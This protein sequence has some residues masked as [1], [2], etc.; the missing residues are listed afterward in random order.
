VD[1]APSGVV[2]FLSRVVPILEAIAVGL[3]LYLLGSMLHGP[4]AGAMAAVLWLANPV[5]MGLGHLDGVDLPVA[6][7]AVLVSLALLRWLRRRGRGSVNL[8]GLACGGAVSAGPTGLLLAAVAVAVV[9]V[10]GWRGRGGQ[11]WRALVPGSAVVVITVA[12]VWFVN[13]ALDTS[14]LRQP[15]LVLPHPYLDGLRGLAPTT[16]G[17]RQHTFAA[18]AGMG[19]DCGTGPEHCW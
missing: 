7:T 19:A 14:V 9:V 10:S 6:L 15:S 4:P 8:V 18:R 2:T 1:K 12:F 3:A 16:P 5:T 11:R 17:A 13:T